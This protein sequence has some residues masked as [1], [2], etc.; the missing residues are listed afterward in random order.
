MSQIGVTSV[1]AQLGYNLM[2]SSLAAVGAL[3]GAAMTDR[4]KRRTVLTFGTL[5]LSVTLAVFSGLSATISKHTE[6][7]EPVP[8]AIGKAAIA[9]YILF[10]VFCGELASLHRRPRCLCQRTRILLCRPSE[11]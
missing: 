4:Q 2:Y 1:T 7:G 10:G 9:V 6:R 5:L 11:R 8:D 3:A